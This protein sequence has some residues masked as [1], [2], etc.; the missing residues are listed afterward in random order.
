LLN[1]LKKHYNLSKEMLGYIKR[2]LIIYKGII[3]KAKRRANDNHVLRAKI[4]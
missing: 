1:G 3:K 2:Y 4:K